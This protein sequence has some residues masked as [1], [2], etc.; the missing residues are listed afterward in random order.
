MAKNLLC[1]TRLYKIYLAMKQRCNN[2]NNKRYKNYGGRGI[3]I[4]EEWS[5]NFISFYNWAISNG[6]DENAK[7]GDCTI[8]RIDVN[9]GYCPENCRWITN[10]E[11]QNNR[12]NNSYIIYKGIK[13]TLQQ[14]S[15]KYNIP[16]HRLFMWY[17]IKTPEEI[18]KNDPKCKRIIISY[19]GFDYPINTWYK[20]SK[21]KWTTLRNRYKS[22]LPVEQIFKKR[23]GEIWKP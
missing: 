19:C 6:Y 17:K 9:C 16:K 5:N 20:L 11:Q 2:K 21:I 23:N 14:F 18:M 3:R 1:E 12:T 7:R 10:K 8:E 22:G 13:Y 4:C 15:E